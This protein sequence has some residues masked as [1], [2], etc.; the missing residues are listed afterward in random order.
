MSIFIL[1]PI[2]LYLA[3]WKKICFNGFGNESHLCGEFSGKQKANA[4]HIL[5]LPGSSTS[6]FCSTDTSP[7]RTSLESELGP[8]LI[9]GLFPNH[10]FLSTVWSPPITPPFPPPVTGGMAH[11]EPSIFC[12]CDCSLA[13]S[14]TKRCLFLYAW[15]KSRELRL[16]FRY[17]YKVMTVA[18]QEGELWLPA[19]GTA[20]PGVSPS[21]AFASI[22]TRELSHL[23]AES[24]RWRAESANWEALNARGEETAL[25]TRGAFQM[26][27]PQ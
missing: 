21:K 22:P 11:T 5:L 13:Q 24:A 26:A 1:V 4:K 18:G 19:G 17:S 15:A 20:S 23:T 2:P 6:L 12:R 8:L 16:K 14:A 7:R 10:P 27:P 9:P 25:V 3:A